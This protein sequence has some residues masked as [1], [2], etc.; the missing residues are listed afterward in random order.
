MS[1]KEVD[2][3]GQL[4]RW[5]LAKK[6]GLKDIDLDLDLFENRIID[7]LGFV[8]FLFYLEQLTGCEIQPSMHSAGSFRTLRAIRDNFTVASYET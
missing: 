7:S 2:L 1:T 8:E 4:K 5:L 3:I 6:P